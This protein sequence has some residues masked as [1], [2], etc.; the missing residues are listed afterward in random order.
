MHCSDRVRRAKESVARIDRYL[1]DTRIL[2]D[3]Q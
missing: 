3:L 1:A 2:T